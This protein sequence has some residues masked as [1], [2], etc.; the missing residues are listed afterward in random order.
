MTYQRSL[1][2][3]YAAVDR[4]SATMWHEERSPPVSPFLI[5]GERHE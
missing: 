1:K 2:T 3:V 4:P 5:F